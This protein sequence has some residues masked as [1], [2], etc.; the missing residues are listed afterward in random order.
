MNARQRE[1]DES[2]A[3]ETT[4]EASDA[5]AREIERRMGWPEPLDTATLMCQTISLIIAA[6]IV[7]NM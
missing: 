3:C 6:V 1:L 7:W 2:I 5:G 4:R